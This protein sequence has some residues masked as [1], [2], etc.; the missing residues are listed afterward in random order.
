MA[1]QILEA[2]PARDVTVN[3]VDV[4]VVH[5]KILSVTESGAQRLKIVSVC[6]FVCVNARVSVCLSLSLFVCVR[7]SVFMFDKMRYGHILIPIPILILVLNKPPC[8]VALALAGAMREQESSRAERGRERERERASENVSCCASALS[9]V[10]DRERERSQQRQRQRQ[11][12]ARQRQT[13]RNINEHNVFLLSVWHT[14]RYKRDSPRCLPQR[15][16]SAASAAA[17]SHRVSTFSFEFEAI[18][19]K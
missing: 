9:K 15:L 16:H 1:Q 10:S 11:R 7:L 13:R 4:D 5:K 17:P 3:D 19:T 12:A 2:E 6:V 18:K 8:L 14:H